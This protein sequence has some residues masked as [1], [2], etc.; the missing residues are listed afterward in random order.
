MTTDPL[1][2]ELLLREGGDSPSP[3]L[4]WWRGVVV[5]IRVQMA[6]LEDLWAQFDCRES[7]TVYWQQKGVVGDWEGV[8]TEGE[9]SMYD[10][11]L[12]GGRRWMQ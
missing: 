5:T 11:V 4:H 8:I 7:V 6:L 1:V 9:L 10:K 2:R 12:L 3:L